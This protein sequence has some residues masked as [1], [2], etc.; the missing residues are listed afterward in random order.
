MPFDGTDPDLGLP[1]YYHIAEIDATKRL[2]ISLTATA[3]GVTKMNA[4]LNHSGENVALL[5]ASME[6]LASEE[7]ANTFIQSASGIHS[8]D[9][10]PEIGFNFED[11]ISSYFDD[12]AVLMLG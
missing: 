9:L 7:T 5:S 3:F 8:V 12:L 4:V 1:N 10:V 2:A 6:L 11:P